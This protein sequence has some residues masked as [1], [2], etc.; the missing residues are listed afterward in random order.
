MGYLNKETITVDAILTKRGRE[1]LAQGNGAFNITRFAVADDEID[2]SLYDTA[3]PLGTEYYGSAIENM[4]IVEASPDTAQNLKSKLVTIT[5][6]LPVN[7]L[8]II[9]PIGASVNNTGDLDIT[10]A[11]SQ[12]EQFIALETKV[13]ATN[14]FD[15]TQ[16]YTAVLYDSSIATLSANPGL[17]PEAS[18]A[19]SNSTTPISGAQTV[20]AKGFKITRKPNV[21]TT[22]T[23]VILITGNESGATL[24]VNLTVVPPTTT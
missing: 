21:T 14:A 23:T 4:P 8:P 13:G 5:N 16:G 24:T 2:Y 22:T 20:V 10:I 15:I 18:G 12:T 3:H 17:D 9:S 7:T 1:L 11:G 6:A 19:S